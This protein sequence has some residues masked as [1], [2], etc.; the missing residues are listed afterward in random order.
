MVKIITFGNISG[1]ESRIAEIERKI[2]DNTPKIDF[3]QMMVETVKSG[4][5]E[6]DNIIDNMS[7]KYGIDKNLVSSIAYAESNKNPKAVS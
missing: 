6:I 5:K 4:K 3:S 7:A 1:I 2:S